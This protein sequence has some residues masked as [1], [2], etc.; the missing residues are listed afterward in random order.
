MKKKDSPWMTVTAVLVSMAV[1]LLFVLRLESLGFTAITLIVGAFI[2]SI[3]S[4]DDIGWGGK[5]SI[6]L[7]L[8]AGLAVILN[9]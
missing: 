4:N 5:I 6:S 3:V 2:G 1:C 8:L 9:S 7:L